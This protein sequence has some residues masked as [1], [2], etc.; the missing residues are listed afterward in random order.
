MALMSS[1]YGRPKT[2]FISLEAEYTVYK[3]FILVKTAISRPHVERHLL[4][5]L[6]LGNIRSFFVIYSG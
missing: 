4:L 6:M 3:S 2:T 5:A 1:L